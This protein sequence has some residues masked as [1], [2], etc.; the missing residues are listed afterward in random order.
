LDAKNL[1]VLVNLVGSHKTSIKS[2]MKLWVLVNLVGSHKTSIKSKM[3][4]TTPCSIDVGIPSAQD[5]IGLAITV[6]ETQQFRGR[7]LQFWTMRDADNL[8][9]GATAIS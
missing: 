8:G 1:W 6:I 9:A 7:Q 5:M 3:K 4:T 2:K